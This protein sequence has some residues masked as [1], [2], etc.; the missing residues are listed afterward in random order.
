MAYIADNDHNHDL[1]AVLAD[2]LDDLARCAPK[3]GRCLSTATT[4]PR[5]PA[6][7]CAPG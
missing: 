6:W 3:G 1:D 2:V 7:Y 5:G 4:A